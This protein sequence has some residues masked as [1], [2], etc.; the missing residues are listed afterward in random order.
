[1]T[2]QEWREAGVWTRT[3]YRIYRNPVVMLGLGGIYAYFIAYRWPAN[4]R[5]VGAWGVVAHNLAVIAYVSAVWALLGVPGL[6]VL[7]ASALITNQEFD[8]FQR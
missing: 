8:N 2:L 5:R 7:G 6:V 4:T 1:M 3:W